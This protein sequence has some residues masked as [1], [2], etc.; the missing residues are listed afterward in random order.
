MDERREIPLPDTEGLYRAWSE[1]GAI[2]LEPDSSRHRLQG[3]GLYASLLFGFLPLGLYFI[4]LIT[5]FSTDYSLHWGVHLLVTILGV[6]FLLVV[7]QQA[8]AITNFQRATLRHDGGRVIVEHRLRGG[9]RRTYTLSEPVCFMVLFHHEMGGTSTSLD[10]EDGNG[11]TRR[12]HFRD[13]VGVD[14]QFQA[15]SVVPAVPFMEDG[16]CETIPH[17]VNVYHGQFDPDANYAATVDAARPL[18]DAIR[19][20]LGVPVEFR[21]EGGTFCERIEVGEE[22]GNPGA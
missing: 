13:L 21:V 19:E 22:F 7:C 3:I 17:R 16:W 18:A 15:A 14:L 12:E 2:H 6:A 5:L 10:V 4:L 9:R 8:F 11:N 20:C 1:S